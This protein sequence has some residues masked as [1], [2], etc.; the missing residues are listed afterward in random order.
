MKEQNKDQNPQEETK[1]NR[2]KQTQSQLNAYLKYSGLAFQMLA[3]IGLAV[4]AGLELDE[5]LELRFPV[6]LV[7]FTLMAV[8]ASLVITIKGLPKN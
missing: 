3:A 5:Y 8:M 4:W 2:K 7:L 6:F 1:N